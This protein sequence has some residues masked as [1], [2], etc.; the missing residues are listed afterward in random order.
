M[1]L[2]NWGEDEDGKATERVGIIRIPFPGCVPP[3]EEGALAVYHTEASCPVC[4]LRQQGR[5]RRLL[6]WCLIDL[7]DLVEL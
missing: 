4:K 2:E 6:T 5:H 3:C 7:L 1:T